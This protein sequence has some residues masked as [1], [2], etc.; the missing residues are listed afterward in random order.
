MT[1]RQASAIVAAARS[2]KGAKWRHR[3]RKPNA[4]DC[5]GLVVLALRKAGLEVD[6]ETMYGREPWEDRLRRGAQARFGDPLEAE[7]LEP[8]DVA[9]FRW[10]TG[11]PTHVGIVGQHPDHTTVLTLIHADNFLGVVEN[12]LVGK[13][14]ESLVEGYRP[15]FPE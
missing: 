15:R 9:I 14:R 2:F 12:S 6:D 1:P 10:E 8:G 13:F 7:E 3:G 4:V 11:E 5:L